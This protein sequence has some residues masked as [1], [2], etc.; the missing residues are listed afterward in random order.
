MPRPQVGERHCQE[1]GNRRLL[2]DVSEWLVDAERP[3]E[4][5][6]VYLAAV[7]FTRLNER[8]RSAFHRA[9]LSPERRVFQLAAGEQPACAF[10]FD[11]DR[12]FEEFVN[13]F[14]ERHR[15][16]I[17]ADGWGGVRLRAQ[18]AGRPT[19]LAEKLP[20]GWQ[21]FRSV[22]GRIDGRIQGWCIGIWTYAPPGP[23]D[24]AGIR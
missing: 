24:R 19:Y 2:R 6:E 9:R 16:R 4:V 3:G 13:R 17:L 1:P 23:E 11:V 22:R 8:F 18:A 7:R 15:R 12:L 21:A 10:V 20:G 14:M 5:P